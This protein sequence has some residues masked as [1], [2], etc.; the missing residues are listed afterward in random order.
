M[1]HSRCLRLPKSVLQAQLRDALA[2]LTQE[3]TEHQHE[4]REMQ[5]ERDQLKS[6]L[7]ELQLSST[8]A[9]ALAS[10]FASLAS[11]LLQASQVEACKEPRGV[12]GP[13]AAAQPLEL[14]EAVAGHR[15]LAQRPKE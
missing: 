3:R 10:R 6:Q 8:A 4:I 15:Q 7:Q 13:H 12:T 11:R 1:P 14:C 5:L 2:L 9:K